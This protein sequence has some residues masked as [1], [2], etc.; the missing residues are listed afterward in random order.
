MPINQNLT[1]QGSQLFSRP[2]GNPKRRASMELHLPKNNF[3]ISSVVD[4]PKKHPDFGGLET[5]QKHET[6]T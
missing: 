3:K 4:F 2:Y 6:H 5:N 1:N